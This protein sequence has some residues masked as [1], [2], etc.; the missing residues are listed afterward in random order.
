MTLKNFTENYLNDGDWTHTYL[1]KA[2]DSMLHFNKVDESTIER[3]IAMVSPDV[4]MDFD[5]LNDSQLDSGL[6][7]HDIYNIN[8]DSLKGCNNISF[9]LM[10]TRFIRKD[11]HGDN[12][13]FEFSGTAKNRDLSRIIFGN[14]YARNYYTVLE[15]LRENFK[16]IK[17]D[18]NVAVVRLPLLKVE[19]VWL[20][21]ID[22][23]ADSY[24]IPLFTNDFLDAEIRYSIHEFF[25]LLRENSNNSKL[26]DNDRMGG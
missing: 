24:F 3:A 17:E 22:D 14:Q 12:F 5:N 15:S 1:T 26:C 13:I 2:K 6:M 8:I 18:Y 11:N 10:G 19:A 4:V 21:I 16:N 9:N 25:E 7:G 20:R 23:M